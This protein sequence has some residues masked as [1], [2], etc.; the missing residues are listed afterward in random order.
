MAIKDTAIDRTANVAKTIE[1]TATSSKSNGKTRTTHEPEGPVDWAAKDREL[2]KRQRAQRAL[3]RRYAPFS[4]PQAHAAAVEALGHWTVGDERATATQVALMRAIDA[5]PQTRRK[6]DALLDLAYD[7]IRAE[8]D[9]I[10]EA[11]LDSHGFA[12]LDAAFDRQLTR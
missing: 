4:R 7:A 9:A 8:R 11:W 2:T 6:N 1:G 12:A 10:C 3:R 5:L